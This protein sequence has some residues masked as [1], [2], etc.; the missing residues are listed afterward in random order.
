MPIVSSSSS[1]SASRTEVKKSIKPPL[2]RLKPIAHWRRR[3]VS[4]GVSALDG[5]LGGG[6]N[7]GLNTVYGLPG[8]GKSTLLRYVFRKMAERN[9]ANIPVEGHTLRFKGALYVVIEKPVEL[10]P[11]AEAGYPVAFYS[12]MRPKPAK[13]FDEVIALAEF[14]DARF[15]VIDSL[16]AA[17]GWES[18]IRGPVADLEKKLAEKNIACV[19]I[20]QTRGNWASIAGGLGVAHASTIV[21]RFEKKLVD[22]KWTAER[23]RKPVGSYVWTVAVEKDALATNAEE[24]GCEYIYGWSG[25]PGDSEPRF[26]R[27]GG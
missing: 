2:W 23:Y 15:V 19:G 6:F 13:L 7:V 26:I 9:P 4:T 22:A 16:T 21:L 18:E 25:A 8:A 3:K 1:F 12:S 5:I 27:V 20:S 11:L 14:L 24:Q 17:F 10:A